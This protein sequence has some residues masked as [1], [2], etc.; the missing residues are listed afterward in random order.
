MH[1]GAPFQPVLVVGS[2]LLPFLVMSIASNVSST[3]NI[4]LCLEREMNMGQCLWLYL[5][6]SY[7]FL[8]ATGFICEHH[9][10]T[11]ANIPSVD[12][13]PAD[14]GSGQHHKQKK[15]NMHQYYLMQC[16]CRRS[17]WK[18]KQD[19]VCH[20][21]DPITWRWSLWMDEIHVLPTAF[22]PDAAHIHIPNKLPTNL[23]QRNIAKPRRRTGPVNHQRESDSK[24]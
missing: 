20:W 21:T 8:F 4:L 14:P 17:V 19:P 15:L 6:F 10:K 22:T 1:L 5:L 18:P 16:V 3:Y 23:L 7:L 13:P 11:K 2:R 9:D 12:L 24:D